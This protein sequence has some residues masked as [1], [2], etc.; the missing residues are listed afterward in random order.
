MGFSNRIGTAPRPIRRPVPPDSPDARPGLKEGKDG[1]K[2]PRGRQPRPGD[3]D[4]WRDVKQGR[5][6]P[7]AR[8]R[9][10]GWRCPAESADCRGYRRRKPYR[11]SRSFQG[12]YLRSRRNQVFGWNLWISP[13]N[14]PNLSASPLE[15]SQGRL[16]AANLR[17][18]V[19]RLAVRVALRS[20]KATA[21]FPDPRRVL[22]AAS[23]AFYHASREQGL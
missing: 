22:I 9:S 21:P 10:P 19:D 11:S 23:V 4:R 3:P 12:L 8:A 2:A 18:P 13:H 6:R 15:R 1:W 16:Q 14:P 7:P 17:C 5:S 20:R